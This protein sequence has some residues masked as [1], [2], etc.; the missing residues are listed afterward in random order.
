[1]TGGGG[2]GGMEAP[3]NIMGSA[4]FA[5]NSKGVNLS[6]MISGCQ[7]GKKYPIHIHQGSS[8]ESAMT[9]GGHWDMMRGEGIPDITCGGRAGATTLMRPN[10]DASLAWTVGDGSATDLVG[11][12]VVIHD[13]DNPMQRIACGVIAKN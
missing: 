3:A 9:Q 1:M 2:A 7:S 10:T 13:A 4:N 6:V 5:S 12:T 11:R 8:C